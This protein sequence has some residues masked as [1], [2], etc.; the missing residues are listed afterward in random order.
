V[1]FRPNPIEPGIW[2][3][4]ADDDDVAEIAPRNDDA[5]RLDL[6][7]TMVVDPMMLA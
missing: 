2:I 3:T 1:G 5:Q 7:T 6:S 4:I